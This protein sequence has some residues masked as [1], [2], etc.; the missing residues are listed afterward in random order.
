MYTTKI[1]A[2]LWRA[3]YAGMWGDYFAE[4]RTRQQAIRR[5]KRVAEEMAKVLDEKLSIA[6]WHN[7][8]I[9]ENGR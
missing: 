6:V 5:Y 4:G 7:T 3:G 9:H 2:H 8:V 1:K